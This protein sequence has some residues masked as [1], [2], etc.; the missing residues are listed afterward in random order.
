[1]Q[2]KLIPFAF[3][4][5]V[6]LVFLAHFG[7][8]LG[9]AIPAFTF[10]D[11][12]KVVYLTFDDGPSTKVTNAVLDVLREE[13]VKA[14]F[15][16][17]S[18]RAAG[19]EDT[20]RRIAREGHSIGVHSKT[21]EYR[22][23]YASDE[24]LLRDVEACAKTIYDLT[25]ISPCL[26][27]FPGGGTEGRK[28]Q[29]ALLTQKGYRVVSWNAVCGDEEIPHASA[30]TLYE[31]AVKTSR[32]KNTVVLLCHD[33]ANHKATAEALPRIISHYREQGYAFR[34]F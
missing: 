21:H 23:I 3:L 31:T 13:D 10:A 4:F 6:L 17:V 27:R 19:R 28:R 8:R 5:V 2:K 7:T 32:G 25:G 12:E 20:L 24:T 1:M 9:A 29:T 14:T 15:F 34:A 26:Y 16:I 30:D 11:A 22:K 33:S 18:D